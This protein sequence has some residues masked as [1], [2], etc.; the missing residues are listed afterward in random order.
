MGT[1]VAIVLKKEG[2]D[3]TFGMDKH[4]RLRVKKEQTEGRIGCEE[5]SLVR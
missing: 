3:W 1:M 2:M 4:R 5:R